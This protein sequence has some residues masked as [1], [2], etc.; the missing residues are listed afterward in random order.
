MYSLHLINF[1]LHFVNILPQYICTWCLGYWIS[2]SRAESETNPDGHASSIKLPKRG[3]SVNDAGTPYESQKT[4]DWNC[5]VFFQNNVTRND[6]NSVKPGHIIFHTG[7]FQLHLCTRCE[8]QWR[9]GC[10]RVSIIH[11]QPKS[12][13]GIS[14]AQSP[15][16]CSTAFKKSNWSCRQNEELQSKRPVSKLFH[17]NAQSKQL[18]RG[19]CFHLCLGYV[20]KLN[21]AE[22]CLTKLNRLNPLNW[23][24]DIKCPQIEKEDRR[25]PSRDPAL[26]SLAW[27]RPFATWLA[28]S[29]RRSNAHP[30]AVPRSKAFCNFKGLFQQLQLR[31]S[32][33]EFAAW[34]DT[35]RCCL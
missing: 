22:Q 3:N 5:R 32:S 17:T 7:L 11:Q 12:W 23:S 33:F 24:K 19:V 10:P 13:V 27:L 31:A 8:L 16:N 2:F 15:N 20:A 28:E 29:E 25:S 1:I 9:P 30:A 14:H 4:T 21:D 26:H 34:L 35:C 18:L 6:R